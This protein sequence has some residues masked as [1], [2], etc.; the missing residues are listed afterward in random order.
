MPKTPHKNK[1]FDISLGTVLRKF[2]L[3]AGLTLD[4]LGKKANLGL[5]RSALSGLE[6]GKHQMTSYQ[7]FQILKTL[8][9]SLNDFFEEVKRNF[10]GF[11]FDGI[12][13]QDKTGKVINIKEL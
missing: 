10:E 13:I 11:K 12:G 6:R 1:K 9:L 3:G 7:L 4:E 5:S 2:R 8:N